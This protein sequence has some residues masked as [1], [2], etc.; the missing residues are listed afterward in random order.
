M[1]FR[2]LKLA[3][4]TEAES[5]IADDRNSETYPSRNAVRL[6]YAARTDM[7]AVDMFWYDGGVLPSAEIMPQVVAT[8]GEVPKSGS[9]MI[10]E[11]GIMLSTGDYGET[12]YVALKGE[13]KVRS[14]SKHEA[15]TVIPETL[16]RC[17]N[18]ESAELHKEARFVQRDGEWKMISMGVSPSRAN[19]RSEFVRACKGEARCYS[20]IDVSVPMMEGVLVGCA[21]QIVPGKLVWD[22]RTQTFKGNR[23]GNRLVTPHIRKGWEY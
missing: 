4:V 8:M 6:R 10:G 20:D 7:P 2:G 21:A 22:T 18:E 23:D 13:D 17:K 9:L 5:M 15:V 16:A 1:P 19:H 14:V 12:A 11:K 3:D